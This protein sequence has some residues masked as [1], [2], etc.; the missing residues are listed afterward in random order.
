MNSDTRWPIVESNRPGTPSFPAKGPGPYMV[1]H[2]LV[3]HEH[4]ITSIDAYVKFF[5]NTQLSNHRLKL[6]LIL[7]IMANCSSFT[8]PS[9]HESSA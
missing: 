8:G 3:F 4:T 9:K 1:R 6:Y 2:Y 7:A 5:R